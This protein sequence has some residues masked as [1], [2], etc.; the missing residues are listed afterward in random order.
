MNRKKWI[1]HNT[2]LE[3][4]KNRGNNNELQKRF[5][6]ER[7]VDLKATFSKTKK[8]KKKNL[9]KILQKISKIINI[10]MKMAYVVKISEKVLFVIG[11]QIQT[12][13]DFEKQVE[14]KI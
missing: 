12:P 13:K 14:K 1:H 6:K 11:N 10:G 5:F 2:I 8:I 4:I 9:A 3:K 7:T